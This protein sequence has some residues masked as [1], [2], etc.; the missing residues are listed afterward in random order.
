M[1]TGRGGYYRDF[2]VI[3]YDGGKPTLSE[4]LLMPKVLPARDVCMLLTLIKKYAPQVTFDADVRRFVY[5]K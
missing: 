5:G 2:L 1:S 4:A 3:A